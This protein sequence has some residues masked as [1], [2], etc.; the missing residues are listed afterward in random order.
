MARKLLFGVLV[1]MLATAL[2]IL[3]DGIPYPTPNTVAA[4]NTFKATTTGNVTGYFVSGGGA[5]LIDYVGLIDVN[6]H[7]FSGWLFN[8]HTTP[9]G[10]T[11]NFGSVNA[12]D[13]LVIEEASLVGLI[14]GQYFSSDPSRSSDGLNHVYSTNWGGGVLNGAYIPA[15]VYFGTEDLPFR[16]SDFN[17]NDDSFVLTGVTVVSSAVP[18]PV[19]LLLFG[20]GILGLALLTGLSQKKHA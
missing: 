1:L 4:T 6:Q 19:S 11:A 2:P 9:V 16:L 7:T 14:F 12:G 10:A 15:G 20:V 18:E 8:N 17:Y 13:T 5:V 3:A